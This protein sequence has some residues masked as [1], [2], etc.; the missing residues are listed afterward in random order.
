MISEEKQQSVRELHQ[1]G[2]SLHAICRLLGISRN[3]VR[4]ILRQNRP[5]PRA[6]TPKWQAVVSQLPALYSQ[7]QGNAVRIQELVQEQL[8]LAIPYS[9]LTHLIRRQGLRIPTPTRSGIYTYAPGED[10]H[11]DTSPH[12]LSIDGKSLTA[13]CAGLI[14]PFSRYGFIQYYPAFTRFEARVFLTAAFGYVGGTSRRCTIDNTSVLVAAGSGP[15]AT[16]AASLKAL[17]E[18]FGV[19]FIPHAVGHPDRKAH[20][21]RLFAYVEGNFL[22]GR[23]FASWQDVNAQARQWCDAVA[24]HKVKRELGTSPRAALEE[25]RPHLRPLPAYIPPVY[26]L[27]HR[28]VDTQGYIH[29]DTNRYSVPERLLGKAVDVF[30]YDEQVVVRFQGKAVAEH[31]RKIGQRRQREQLPGHHSPLDVAPKRTAPSPEEQQL[32]AQHPLLDRYVDALKQRS[33]GRGVA[34]LKRLLN[35]QRTYPW[36]PFLAAL[37]RAEHY[38]LYDLNRLEKLI[39]EQLSGS[40]FYL[41][42]FD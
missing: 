8:N 2:I 41:E 4:R 11:H 32:R 15:D 19:Q 28:R 9:T 29:L 12:R 27:V 33:P 16:I 25:E 1:Q 31:H 34:K 23:T 5:A 20:V 14:L 40:F 3:S 7:T 37:E 6:P 39:L 21:E 35:L 36:E 26:D 38:A 18:H 22:A 17:G 10:M 13:Q 24:N 42:D 30:K